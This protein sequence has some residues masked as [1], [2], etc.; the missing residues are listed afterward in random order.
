[1]TANGG[2]DPPPYRDS[3]SEDADFE[4]SENGFDETSNATLLLGEPPLLPSENASKLVRLKKNLEKF[5]ASVHVEPY[6]P[7]EGLINGHV[8][9][10]ERPTDARPR[11]VPP[12]RAE[13]TALDSITSTLVNG[14]AHDSARTQ[15]A[16][17]AQFRKEPAAHSTHHDYGDDSSDSDGEIGRQFA[18]QWRRL[19]ERRGAIKST[20]RWM[21][22]QRSALQDANEERYQVYRELDQAIQ[23]LLPLDPDLARLFKAAEKSNLKC[24]AEE[25]AFDDSLVQLEDEENLVEF[26][27]RVFYTNQT[28]VRRP[29]SSWASLRGITGI[30]PEDAH[31]LFK[32]FENAVS[33]IGVAREWRASMNL[34]RQIL[35][36]LPR[37]EL[38]EDDQEF[39]DEYAELRETAESELNHWMGVAEKLEKECRKMQVIPKDSPFEVEGYWKNPVPEEDNILDPIDNSQLDPK[40]LT[41]PVF[42]RLLSSPRHLL[43][44]PLPQTTERSLHVASSL[45]PTHR[46]KGRLIQDAQKELE[47]ETLLSDSQNKEEFINKWLLQKLRQST[48]EAELLRSTFQSMLRILNMDQWQR[49]VLYYWSRDGTTNQSKTPAD[50]TRNAVEP[51]FSTGSSMRY[52]LDIQVPFEPV[53]G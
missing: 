47:I 26:E 25:M 43:V 10:V 51:P 12:N 18:R 11:S 45:P 36:Q 22:L 19:R 3:V 35:Q 50:T 2:A 8:G 46:W 17:P 31:P 13:P 4:D 27:E 28:E 5:Q 23:K 41:H 39:L 20:L 49:D 1:M 30:R 42:S 48:M 32:E 34:R 53:E 14:I 15:P 24:Q 16:A 21:W 38:S 9:I 33:E 7:E 40:A 37:D 44:G 29:A 6:A 52:P